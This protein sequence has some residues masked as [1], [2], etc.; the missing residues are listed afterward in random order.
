M[1]TAC[2][3]L[4]G[5][6]AANA[7]PLKLLADSQVENKAALA[8]T[9]VDGGLFDGDSHDAADGAGRMVLSYQEHVCVKLAWFGIE[10]LIMMNGRLDQPAAKLELRSRDLELF[11][12]CIVRCDIVGHDD[13]GVSGIRHDCTY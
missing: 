4:R 2:L 12:R 13:I 9:A 1:L 6:K 8:H 11:T 7:T 10:A 3:G 5:E